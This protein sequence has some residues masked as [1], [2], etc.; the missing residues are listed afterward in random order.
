MFRLVDAADDMFFGFAIGAALMAFSL[1]F[2]ARFA[3]QRS[4]LLGRSFA[5]LAVV[6]VFGPGTVTRAA[7]MGWDRYWDGP[8]GIAGVAGFACGAV[9]LACYAYLRTRSGVP[10]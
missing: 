5:C 4:L 3:A 1:C 9:S 7:K 6:W 10:R 2:T 8:D